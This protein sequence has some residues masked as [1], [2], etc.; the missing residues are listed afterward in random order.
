MTREVKLSL[1]LGFAVVL[2]VGVLLSDHLSG[3]RQARTEGLDPA[4]GIVPVT[5]A[6]PAP[7]EPP[8]LILVDEN[9]VPQAPPTRPNPSTNPRPNL[10]QPVRVAD[11][12]PIQAGPNGGTLLE[13]FQNR[14]SDAIANAVND[15]RDGEVPPGA[16]QLATDEQDPR[17]DEV[18]PVD[19]EPSVPHREAIAA[20]DDPPAEPVGDTYD[21][22]E[23]DT[24]WSIASRLLGDGKRH[25]EIVALNRDRIGAGNTLR[26]GTTLRLPAM[27]RQARG[28]KPRQA[29][30]S[31]PVAAATKKN[32]KTIYTVKSGDT[33]GG[34][35]AK[36]LGSSA[37]YDQLL[38]TCCWP[39]RAR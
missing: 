32:G 11:A 7:N 28:E 14:A 20:N 37:K 38:P 13:Q 16:F 24:L 8:G 3:A 31:R 19:R 17:A 26:V 23:G 25:K 36:F 2:A 39:T 22:R 18:V 10:V 5:A 12:T 33:L 15:L 21:V 1:I 9:G 27:S 34:I 4:R 35:A 29:E 6:T 30:E